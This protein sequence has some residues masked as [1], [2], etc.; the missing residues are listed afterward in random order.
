MNIGFNITTNNSSYAA[1]ATSYFNAG[2]SNGSGCYM[3]GVCHLVIDVTDTSLVTF[4]SNVCTINPSSNLDATGLTYTVTMASGVI[5]NSNG[6]LFNGISGTAYQFNSKDTT[7]PSAFT[8]GAITATGGTVATNYWN[9][10]NTGINITVPVAND[11]T[12][13]GGTIQLRANVNSEGY[14]NLDSAYPIVS[15]D[16]SSNKT[17]SVT[18]SVFEALSSTLADSDVDRPL[19]LD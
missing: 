9:S 11:T 14:T 17:I 4:S 6:D 19:I 5:K 16:I 1:Q 15:G 2:V 3:N 12:L 10:T 8:V 13:I 18:A 7:S